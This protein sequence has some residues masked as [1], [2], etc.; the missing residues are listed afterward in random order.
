M[1]S[2]VIISV[3]VL[4]VLTSC[5][6]ANMP[7]QGSHKFT[8]S[9][10]TDGQVDV[11]YFDNTG[12]LINETVTEKKWHRTFDVNI[13]DTMYVRFFPTVDCMVGYYFAQDG[14]ITYQESPV[15]RNAYH[16]NQGYFIIKELK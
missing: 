5:K 6:K 8:Y 15:F 14:T 11:S 13:G 7:T 2:I 9:I 1:K 4:M 10:E 12:T 3:F 16:G